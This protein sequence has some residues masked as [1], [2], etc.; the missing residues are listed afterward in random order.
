MKTSCGNIRETPH[1]DVLC[2]TWE[3]LVQKRSIKE[4][5]EDQEGRTCLAY[6][7]WVVWLNLQEHSCPS[8]LYFLLFG[9]FDLFIS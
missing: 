8:Y 6:N 9:L 5:K 3:G 2:A 1:L 4:D 7:L